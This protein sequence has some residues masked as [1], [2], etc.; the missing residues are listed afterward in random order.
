M[1]GLRF[2]DTVHGESNTRGPC[3]VAVSRQHFL[4]FSVRLCTQVAGSTLKK[5][6]LDSYRNSGEG[7]FGGVAWY[8]NE[9]RHH[10]WDLGL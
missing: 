6:P 9:M 3:A 5:L 8:L 7:R 10:S 4:W 2:Q 1:K